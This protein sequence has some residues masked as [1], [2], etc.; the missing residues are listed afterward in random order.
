MPAA[1]QVLATQPYGFRDKFPT[2]Y[3]IEVFIETSSDLHIQSSTWT[4][5]ST[6]IQ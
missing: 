3:V 4:H 5:T 6:T 2:T 1:D